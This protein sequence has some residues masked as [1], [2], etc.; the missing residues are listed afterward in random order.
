M[1]FLKSERGVKNLADDP[2]MRLLAEC[3]ALQQGAGFGDVADLR[4]MECP[5]CKARGFNTGLGYIKFECTA[6]V[7]PDGEW[8]VECR[9]PDFR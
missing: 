9:A 2:G 1:Q 5:T 3:L 8:S 4:Q 7:L 6:E